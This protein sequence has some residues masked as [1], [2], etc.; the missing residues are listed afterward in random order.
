MCCHGQKN[1]CKK[2]G[3]QFP[4][5]NCFNKHV[6]Y[7]NEP[8]FENSFQETLLMLFAGDPISEQAKYKS[9]A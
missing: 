8:N 4:L 6:L 9:V 7:F 5:D 2:K 3:T 1:K